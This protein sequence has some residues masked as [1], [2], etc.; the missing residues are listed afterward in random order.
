LE[1]SDEVLENFYAK[2]LV[3]L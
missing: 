3:H 2:K 1:I